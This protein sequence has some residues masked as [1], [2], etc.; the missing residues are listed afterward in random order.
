MLSF[1]FLALCATDPAADLAALSAKV[2]GFEVIAL[3]ATGT[4]DLSGK[5]GLIADD[6]RG[7]ALGTDPPQMGTPAKPYPA[8]MSDP[9][10]PGEAPYVADGIQPFRFTRFTNEFNYGGWHN[11]TM[12]DY[13]ATRGFGIL[14]KY[15]RLPE[16]FAH[17]PAGTRVLS[18][19]GFVNWHTW[20]PEHG[21]P[22]GRYD[23]LV[24]RDLVGEL[25]A[26]GKFK[27]E[28]G[29]VRLMIDMEHGVLSPDKLHEQDWFPKDGTPAA[30]AAFE[31][32][33]YDGYAMTYTV[34]VQVAREAGWKNISLYGWQPFGR[35]WF[36][37][38]KATAEPETY[39][40]WLKYGQQIEAA[41]DILNPS[42]YCF[43]WSPQN[44]AYTLANLD[45]NRKLNDS[46]PNP[47]PMVPYYWTLLHGGGGGWRWWAGQP[48]GDEETRAMYGLAFFAGIDGFDTW[49]WS[50][51]G[52]HHEPNIKVDAD[53]MIGEPF[54][55][56][57][58]NAD[59]T[60][61]FVK[62]DVVHITAVAEDGKVSFQEVIKD[63][64]GAHYGV[65]EGQPTFA[66]PKDELAA[67]VRVQSAPVAAM[68][69]GLA[70]VKPFEN[71]L[72]DGEIKVDVSAQEQYAKTLPIVRRVKLGDYHLLATYDPMVQFGGEPR[73]ITLAD[74]DG[75]EGR[76]LILPADG[77]LRLFALRED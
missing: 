41:V 42:V 62:Y 37:I 16:A 33:Y 2:P 51:T 69:E 17:Y 64:V 71:L 7:V 36:G 52:S 46:F 48:L 58:D 21:I 56:A 30:Q 40:P 35:M 44:V 26:S 63:Q 31:K 45:L 65:G 28:P 14:T 34:P 70:L 5:P 15:N 19:G 50:G 6:L 22:E 47:K 68:V 29:Y 75:V 53:L 13:A 72:R 3:P 77:E 18:W 20:L 4:L 11:W 73:N 27:L 8:N 12:M 10:A 9:F 49:N 57:A 74:F 76:T 43:Y 59:E 1:L 55:L 32:R 39:W 23:Q 25:T 54:A 67:H 24:G 66:M 60:T 61:S 38:D